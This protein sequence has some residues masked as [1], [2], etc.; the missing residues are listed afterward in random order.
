MEWGPER[1]STKNY[2][3]E[4][5]KKLNRKKRFFSHIVTKRL[6]IVHECQ[7]SALFKKYP[8]K[9]KTKVLQFIFKNKV[10]EK[11]WLNL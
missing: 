10:K 1:K 11:H 8:N 9:N 5:E 7:P 4:G 6:I 2:E 3:F